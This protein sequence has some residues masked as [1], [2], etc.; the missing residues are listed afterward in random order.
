MPSIRNRRRHGGR[1]S[2]G[3]GMTDDIKLTLAAFA[4]IAGFGVALLAVTGLMA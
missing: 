2:R 3:V 1:V 4:A